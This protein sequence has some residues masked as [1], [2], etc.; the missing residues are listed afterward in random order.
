MDEKEVLRYVI[1][2]FE[3][4]PAKF[5]FSNSYTTKTGKATKELS[6]IINDR[7]KKNFP[8]TRIK[9]SFDP[10][11]KTI[12]FHRA[13]MEHLV[14]EN[15]IRLLLSEED[16]LSLKKKSFTDRPDRTKLFVKKLEDRNPIDL[17]NG[18]KVVID[19]I[20]VDNDVFVKKPA[21]GERPFKDLVAVL[22]TL[23]TRSKIMFYDDLE[24]KK[25]NAYKISAFAKT[26]ELGGLG[27]KGSTKPEQREIANL[28]KQ[29]EDIDGSI[30]LI[31]DGEE[32]TNIDGIMDVRANRKADFAFTSNRKPVIYISYK[33]GSSP[34]DMISYGGITKEAEI[35][36]VR[37]FI[38]AVKSK[39]SSMKDV[40]VEY[41]YPVENPEVIQ[42]VLYGF[43][44]NPEVAG[45]N[46]VQ[47]LIQGTGLKLEGEDGIYTLKASHILKAPEIPTGDYAPYYNA[48]YANDR[49][50]FGIQNCRFTVVPFGARKNIQDPFK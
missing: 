20:V 23:T 48:R 43:E 41:G 16:Y 35:E 24:V 37:N 14:M 21:K 33:P 39:T 44:Y 50:Q 28:Q 19:K 4:I 45:E 29:F 32:F 30:T 34:K 3:L 9:T 25:A 31:I 11:Y 26:P 22:P 7:I 12:N 42:K 46:S 36:E 1:N 27:K 13:M 2:G 40:R 18:N 5:G 47:F 10:I 49:S 17:T 38:N 8:Q 15:I 6:N